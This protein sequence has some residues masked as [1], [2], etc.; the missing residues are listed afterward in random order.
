MTEPATQDEVEERRLEIEYQELCND[1]RLR[2]KYVLDKLGVT[3]ILFGLLGLA[4]GNIPPERPL[5]KLFLLFAGALFSFILCVSVSKD[6][7]F[8]DGTEAL[9][10]R[11]AFRL[12]ITKSLR[13]LKVLQ[14][15]DFDDDIDFQKL[16]VGRRV[17]IS[18]KKSTL[19]VFPGWLNNWISKQATF[20]WILGFYMISFGVFVI[21][22]IL[23][24][25]NWIFC[26]NLPI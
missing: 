7:L 19:K 1:W 3:S 5:I 18:A 11:L 12:G 21:L 26:L 24:L 9:L 13:D 16:Q 10:K 25:V 20:R 4:V 8:R 23:I 6:I 2:D 15:P 22:F 17:R 14:S